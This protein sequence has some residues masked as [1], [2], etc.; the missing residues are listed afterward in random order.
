[1]IIYEHEIEKCIKIKVYPIQYAEYGINDDI[2][3]ILT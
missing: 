2:N 3:M 1:M